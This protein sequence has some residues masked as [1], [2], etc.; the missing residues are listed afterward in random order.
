MSNQVLNIKSV[1]KTFGEHRVLKEVSLS[2]ESGSFLVIF[3][4]NGAGKTTL[5]R[6]I[7]TLDMPDAGSIEVLGFDTRSQSL[8]VRK[9]VGFISHSAMLYLDQSALDNL[10]YYGKLYGVENPRERAFELLDTFGLSYRSHDVVRQ[11]SRGMLQRLAI[12]RALVHDPELV[13]LDE[14]H[15]GLDPYA[16]EVV[17]ALC[18]RKEGRSFVMVS[19]DIP[20]GLSLCT[21]YMMLENGRVS[22]FG[23]KEQAEV[24]ERLVSY[25]YVAHLCK[26]SDEKE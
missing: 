6:Q 22:A 8:E 23:T 3:G 9:R 13:L 4:P 10:M 24:E 26:V 15:T 5:L 14:P 11:F 20:K 12:A 16:V 18:K 7:A 2:L 19:H 25:G 21:H 1:K 17:D